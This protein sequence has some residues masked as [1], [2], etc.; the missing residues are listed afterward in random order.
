MPDPTFTV[1]IAV[2]NGVKTIERA[3]D[4][5]ASQTYA[6]WQLVVMDGGST[7]GTREIL[8]SRPDVVH[9]LESASD[10][11]I[12]HAWNKALRVATG[13]W[14]LFLGADDRIAD[15]TVMARAAALLPRGIPPRVA[16]GQVRLLDI[17]GRPIGLEGAPWE[18]LK[19]TFFK[20]NVMPHQGVLHHRT[21]FTR[22]GDFDES[23]RIVGDYEFLLRELREFRPAFMPDLVVANV[24]A[25]GLSRM[26]SSMFA[27]TREQQRALHRHGLGPSEWLTFRVHRSATYEVIRRL[28]GPKAARSSANVYKRVTRTRP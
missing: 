8:E 19:E 18:R 13:E 7:D 15:P 4:S 5:V 24:E 27:A 16:Y 20:R 9:Y 26:P 2:L 21:L 11:G 12:C 28:F 25:A 6:S 17:G 3:L 10:R 23:F 22:N 1:V 14:V